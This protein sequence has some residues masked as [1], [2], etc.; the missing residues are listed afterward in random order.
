MTLPRLLQ[1]T[2]TFFS[3]STSNLSTQTFKLVVCDFAASLGVSASAA[4]FK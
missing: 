4:P 3:L 1:S 2:G